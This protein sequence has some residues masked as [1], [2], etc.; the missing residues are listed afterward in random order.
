MLEKYIDNFEET[1]KCL[2]GTWNRG[3]GK[4]KKENIELFSK[5]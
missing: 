1:E 4:G 3:T 5:G 2:H